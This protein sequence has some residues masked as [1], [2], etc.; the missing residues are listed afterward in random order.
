MQ[1]IIWPIVQNDLSYITQFW[2]Q[3]GF[4]LW[5]EVQGSSF[6]TIA[7]QHRALVEGTWLASHISTSCANCVSQAP[8]VLCFLQSFWSSSSNSLIANF[9]GGRSGRDANTILGVI[10]TFDP[11]AGCD[12][13]TFQPCSSRALAS[14]KVTTDAFRSI[15]TINS[16]IPEGQ[17]VAVGRYPEDSYMGGNPWY[18]NTAA[19][20]EQ[21]YYAIFQWNRIGSITIDSTSLAF[22]KDIFPSAAVGTFA[23]S[24]ST[25]ASIVAAVKTYADGYLSVVVC[26]LPSLATPVRLRVAL[27]V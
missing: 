8:Q 5:E 21:L 22:F 25:F 24:T 14:H 1:N 6:F 27:S 12:S 19:A 23:S 3:T 4:D 16:G 20:A 17:A 7:V 10:H 2:N 11:E 15:Y 13:T 9:G 18:I 26:F